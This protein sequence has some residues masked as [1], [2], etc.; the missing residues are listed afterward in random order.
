MGCAVL[1]VRTSTVCPFSSRVDNGTST[2][3]NQYAGGVV[4]DTGV[5]GVCKVQ[6]GCAAAKIDDFALGCEIQKSGPGTG[7]TLRR[8]ETPS[9]RCCAVVLQPVA[10]TIPVHAPGPN[11]MSFHH[12]CIASGLP[13]LFRP[14]HPSP[15]Y[16]SGFRR[17]VERAVEYGVK[18]LVTIG[19]GQGNVVFEAP[20][21]GAVKPVD[22]AECQV[23]MRFGVGDDAKSIHIVHLGKRQVFGQH[24]P[25]NAVRGFFSALDIAGN[26]CLVHFS[27]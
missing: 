24:F 26:T 23:T 9:N 1:S 12:S 8:R 21:F 7:L 22:R 4:A 11:P 19:F 5:D 3:S 16:G 27:F 13:R 20:G 18:R 14:G 17:A 15:G 10:S 25:V 2:L 6:G